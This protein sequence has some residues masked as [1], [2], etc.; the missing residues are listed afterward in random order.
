MLVNCQRFLRN[1]YYKITHQRRNAYA[2]LFDYLYRIN[3]DAFPWISMI[4]IHK[5]LFVTADFLSPQLHAYNGLEIAAFSPYQVACYWLPGAKNKANRV[6]TI[7]KHYVC[8]K[9]LDESKLTYL[10]LQKMNETRLHLSHSA[11]DFSS[12]GE[13]AI[14][15]PCN[16]L[17]YRLFQSELESLIY[18]GLHA[19]NLQKKHCNYPEYLKEIT[20]KSEGLSACI[21]EKVKRMIM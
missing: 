16:L 17:H 3:P 7:G 9:L 1:T 4:N 15:L 14:Y 2:V 5:P 21:I 12:L 20:K 10:Y 13:R 11:H 19:L 8:L 18:H 6:G